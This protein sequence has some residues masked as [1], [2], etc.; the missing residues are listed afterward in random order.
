MRVYKFPFDLQTC[1]ITFRSNMYNYT[2]G[3]KVGFKVTILLA[4][5]IMQLILNEIL[6]SSSEKIP[7]IVVYCIGIF[8]L[9]MLSLLETLFVIHLNGKDSE[10]QDNKT[11]QDQCLAMKKYGESS[12]D[13]SAFKTASAAKEATSIQQ[14]DGPLALEK[15]SDELREMKK[16]ITLLNSDKREDKRD[17]WTKLTGRINKIFGICY[18]IS[19]VFLATILWLREDDYLCE[20][21]HLQVS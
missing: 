13:A 20:P 4:V 3:E 17:Y 6:P 21:N 14:M 16:M 10:L 11:A 15:F 9:M 7:L 1:N 2:G 18:V 8:T 12:D 19:V 5:T